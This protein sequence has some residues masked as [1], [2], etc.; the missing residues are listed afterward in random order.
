MVC[1]LL[2]LMGTVIAIIRAYDLH[3]RLAHAH[4]PLSKHR[5]D[6]VERA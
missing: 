1:A 6:P 3:E 4:H 5:I 2:F